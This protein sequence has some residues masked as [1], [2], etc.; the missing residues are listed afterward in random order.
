MNR[1]GQLLAEGRRF[2]NVIILDEHV[3]M[4][5]KKI[6]LSTKILFSLNKKQCYIF[7]PETG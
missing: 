5:V 4:H 1:V 3:A 2:A 7:L 6:N